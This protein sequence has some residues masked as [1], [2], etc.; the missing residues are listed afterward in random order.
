MK[1]EPRKYPTDEESKPLMASEP[2]AAYG[3]APRVSR[4]AIKGARQE[5]DRCMT[6]EEFGCHLSNLIDNTHDPETGNVELA[7]VTPKRRSLAEIRRRSITL[8]ELYDSLQTMVDD[9][10]DSKA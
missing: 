5:T 1:K 2:E 4:R 3:T 9:Y 8:D 10:Y 7:E 6:L